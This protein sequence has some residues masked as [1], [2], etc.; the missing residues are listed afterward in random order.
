MTTK[1]DRAIGG[2]KLPSPIPRTMNRLSAPRSAPAPMLR[3][4]HWIYA[5][6]DGRI[7][8]GMIGTWTLLLRT[9]GRRSGQ[10]RSTALVFARDGDRIIVA[11]SNDGK[12]HAPAW[13]HNLRSQ[14]DVEVQVGRE[15]FSGSAT[16]I[17]STHVD[18]PRLWDLMNRTNNGRYDAYQSKTSRSIPLVAIVPRTRHDPSCESLGRGDSESRNCSQEAPRS[19]WKQEGPHG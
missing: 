13:F 9:V 14:R 1:T 3:F 19:S 6:S 17:E 10:P 18:Y 11:A 8:P 2:D 5:R 15:H 16:V 4:H 7:G 12:E